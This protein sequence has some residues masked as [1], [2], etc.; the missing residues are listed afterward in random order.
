ML[1]ALLRG[2]GAGIRYKIDFSRNIPA[3]PES[4]AMHCSSLPGGAILKI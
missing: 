1:F 4:G 2:A 3:I